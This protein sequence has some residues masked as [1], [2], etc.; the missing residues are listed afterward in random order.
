[1]CGIAETALLFDYKAA[2]EQMFNNNL[3]KALQ[4]QKKAAEYCDSLKEENPLLVSNIYSNLGSLYL[5]NN[6]KEKAK[7]YMELAYFVLKDAGL[8]NSSDGITQIFNYANLAA[9]LGEHEKAVAAL[10]LC[11]KNLEKCGLSMT[12]KYANILWGIGLIYM[13][14]GKIEKAQNRLDKAWSIYSEVWEDEPELLEA[15]YA[16]LKGIYGKLS[17]PLKYPINQP[18]DSKYS[19]IVIY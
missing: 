12:A 9:E 8:E 2:F 11:A 14:M 16:E 4:Y 19:L 5:A 7:E 18:T 3:S 10:E 1:M 17:I 13:D 6:T 15:K